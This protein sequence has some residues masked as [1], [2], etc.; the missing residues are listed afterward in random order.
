MCIC[1]PTIRTPCCGNDSCHSAAG[2]LSLQ[3]PWCSPKPKTKMF[4]IENIRNGGDCCV[5]W[6]PDGKGY[7]R[8][9]EEAWKVDETRARDICRSRPEQDVMREAKDVDAQSVRHLGR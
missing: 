7:T 1:N 9:L 3:C 4:Y 2:I 6:R 8:N 5:W